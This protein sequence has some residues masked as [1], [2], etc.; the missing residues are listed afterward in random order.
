MESLMNSFELEIFFF[1]DWYFNN[2]HQTAYK[3]FK[4]AMWVANGYKNN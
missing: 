3:I 2:S 4:S 1:S